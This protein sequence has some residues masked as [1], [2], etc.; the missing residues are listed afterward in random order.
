MDRIPICFFCERWASG[1]IESFLYNLLSRWDLSQWQVHVVAAC[2][3]DSIFTEPLRQRGVCFLELSGDIHDLRE[4][5][6]RFR[7]LLRENRYHVVH[8]HIYHGLSLYYARIARQEGVPLRIAH[9]HNGDLRK[10]PARWLKL[11]IHGWSR[12]CLEKD[13]THLLACS[14]EAGEFLFGQKACGKRKIMLVPNGIDTERFCFD[15]EERA[16][17]REDLRLAGEFVLGSVGRL[18]GQKN[19]EFLLEVFAHVVKTIPE[20]RLL[21]VGDGEDREQLQSLAQRLGIAERVMFCGR[22]S[23]VQELLWAMDLYLQPSRFEGLP[24]SVVEAQAAGLPVICSDRITKEVKIAESLEFLS[25]E[26][27]ALAWADAV[28]AKKEEIDGR[29]PQ[30]SVR[31]GMRQSVRPEGA[32]RVKA[33][34]YDIR[35]VV[36]QLE[37]IYREGER[38]NDII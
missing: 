35:T 21:L 2:L 14:R 34:G 9:S 4:N 13:A 1:G 17:V 5:H 29:E 6:R 10:S 38:Q 22:V 3:E 16:R 27:G 36:D 32:A 18:C 23:G 24:V 30:Q 15:E 11:W 20:S 7:Q 25:L 12:S 33:A 26:Q 37:R 31:Q 19:Q 8:L 28:V